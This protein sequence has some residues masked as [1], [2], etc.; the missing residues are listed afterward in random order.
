MSDTET[1]KNLR[2]ARFGTGGIQ[3][4]YLCIQAEMWY[5]ESELDVRGMCKY[6]KD[7]R[8]ERIHGIV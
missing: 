4:S 5:C 3:H 1:D 7:G 8:K 6:R 2:Y